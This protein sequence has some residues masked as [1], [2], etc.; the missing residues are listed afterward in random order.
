MSDGPKKPT[1]AGCPDN[2]TYD[3]FVP[4]KSKGVMMH[5]GERFC[6]HGKK[7]RRFKKRDPQKYV[8]DWCPKRKA[9]CELRVYTF[10]SSFDWWMHDRLCHDLGRELSPEARRY[11][12]AHGLHT[13]LTPQD[14]WN[15]CGHE[16]DIELLS[17]KVEPHDVVEIDDGLKPVFFYKAGMGYRMLPSFDAGRARMNKREV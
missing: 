3:D 6:T 4:M 5:L 17:V 12:L 2:F 13:E 10:K 15:R 11:T 16:T 7:A 8:P 1:C 14:F 9:P